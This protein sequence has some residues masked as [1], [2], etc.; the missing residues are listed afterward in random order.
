LNWRGCS[1]ISADFGAIAQKRLSELTFAAFDVETTGLDSRADRVVEVGAVKFERSGVLETYGQLVNPG[2]PIPPALTAIHGITDE[3]V[4]KSPPI[5]SVITEFVEFAGD[6]VLVAHNAQFDVGFFDAAFAEACIEPLS[7]PV[8]CTRELSRGV[9]LGLSDYKLATLAR[10]LGIPAVE[11]HHALADAGYSAEVFRRCMGYIDPEW[12][13]TLTQLFK[14]HGP[15]FRF[16]PSMVPTLEAIR[17]ALQSGRPVR[18]EYRSAA[19]EVTHR[20]ITPLQID[21]YGLSKKVVAYC[22]LRRENRTFR[23]DCILRIL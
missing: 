6:A 16:K 15:F 20:D 8:L 3:M 5:T 7:T 2:R 11:H 22:H 1:T 23:L 4:A 9:F 13:M 21:G 14:Y 19:G 12:N 17:Q 10:F 18:I